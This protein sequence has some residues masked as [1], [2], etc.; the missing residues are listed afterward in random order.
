MTSRRAFTAL[1][2]LETHRRRQQGIDAP[3]TVADA[4]SV[5]V[6]FREVISPNPAWSAAHRDGLQRFAAAIGIM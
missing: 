6:K 2:G 1:A 3:F 4:V 5:L